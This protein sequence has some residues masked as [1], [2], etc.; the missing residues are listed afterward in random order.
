[1]I[2][3]PFAVGQRF[4][5]AA[6][7]ELV[8]FEVVF[9]VVFDVVVDAAL[10]EVLTVLLEDFLEEDE[11]DEVIVAACSE[12]RTEMIDEAIEA[13]ATWLVELVLGVSVL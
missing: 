13:V 9:D 12:L 8:V 1:M 4:V 2:V 7:V 5:A 6:E 10:E 3:L 11:T